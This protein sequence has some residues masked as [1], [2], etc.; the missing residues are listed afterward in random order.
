MLL[1]RERQF[2]LNMTHTKGIAVVAM[3]ASLILVTGTAAAQSTV[4]QADADGTPTD[5]G[6]FSDTAGS[7]SAST[8]SGTITSANITT[9]QSTEAWAGLYGNATGTLVLGDGTDRLYEWDAVA[10]Y[11]FASTASGVDFTNVQALNDISNLN[12]AVGYGD[13]SDNATETYNTTA[14][15]Y[16]GSTT[17]A[18]ES[19]DGSNNAAWTT[20][21]E[22]VNPGSTTLSD[23]V[24][25]A[26]AQPRSA[27]TA[28]DGSQADYQ[29]LVPEDGTV[30]AYN[31][32]LELK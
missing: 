26:V 2:S 1:N 29:A 32:Y 11:V 4:N 28:Y 18:A 24:F 14:T 13:Q 22:T 5:Q 3:V 8:S 9:E 17:D 10:D 20:A 30:S 19:F 23:F 21:V 27:T 31:L 6:S 15:G 12:S 25:T 7:A 16:S